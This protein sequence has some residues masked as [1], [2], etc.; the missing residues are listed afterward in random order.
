MEIAQVKLGYT[1]IYSYG[2][3]NGKCILWY[4]I[5]HIFIKHLLF[6]ISVESKQ[7]DIPQGNSLF[8]EGTIYLKSKSVP[9]H[10]IKTFL[11]TKCM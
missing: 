6:K 10:T 4:K 1:F 3:V 7:E 5:C 8:C 11:T 9:Y 2:E